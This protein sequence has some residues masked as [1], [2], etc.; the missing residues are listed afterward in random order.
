MKNLIIIVIALRIATATTLAQTGD[1]YVNENH[2][3]KTITNVSHPPVADHD[4]ATKKYVDDAIGGGGGVTSFNSR[5]GVVTS[6]ASDYSS[7]Y[8]PASSVGDDFVTFNSTTGHVLKDSGLFRDT[9]GT[10]TAN[11]DSRIPSQK[12][13]KTY[14]DNS[15]LAGAALTKTDDT[16]ITLTLGGSPTTAL[17]HAASLTLGWNG[18]LA[19]ARG[20]T[21]SGT[22]AGARTNLGA[23]TTGANLFTVSDPSAIRFVKI[24]ADNSVTLDD[25]AS[26]RT[27]IGAGTGGGDFS[28]NTSTSV[29]SEFILFSGTTGKIGKRAT[30]S[31]VALVTSGVFS[32]GSVDLSGSNAS[33]I[34][35]AG[36]F[37]ALTGDVTTSAGSLTTSIASSVNLSG[38]P[39]TTTQATTDNSTRIATTA[40]VTTGIS[41][42]IAGVNPAVAVQAATTAASDTSGFTYS[43]GVGGIGATL[44]GPTNNVAVTFD[45]YTFTA[46]GQRALVKND[47][48]SPSGAFNGVYYV[49]TLQTTGVKPILTRA[50]DFDMP[51][52]INNTGAIPVVNGTANGTTSWVLTSNVTTVGTDPLT[53]T[54]FSLK[55][56]TLVT[57]S[58]T[59]TIGGT[60]QDL[61][62]DRSWLGNVTNDAQIKASDFPS[63]SV[64]SEVVLFSSTTGKVVK[65][66][67]ATGIAKLASG[68]LS[69]V[70][71]PSGAI[72]GDTDTQTLTNKRVNPRTT[73]V[74]S[75]TTSVTIDSDAN[76]MHVTTAQA[77]ALL[78][79]NPSGTPVQ[80]QKLLIRIK[81]N[82]T[83]R[84]LTYGTQFRASSDLALPTTTVVSK[85]LYMG[86]IWNVEDSKWDLL[87]VL[88]NF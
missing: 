28:S 6:Q 19:V 71:A 57:T 16:N 48:Q 11:S 86:F 51:G 44:T 67:S 13:V 49:T 84:A 61:S 27:D 80:G 60:A 81:D 70:T 46:L 9:D 14:V 24:N 55:P 73:T 26:F 74:S 7:I 10:F 76:D 59:L 65:R 85:T 1:I 64:D 88:N 58:R 20:G 87:A 3:N 29:D 34:L 75:T 12:A 56:S 31:G 78:Y 47:T 54:E 63:S 68:V 41:N 52:D 69:S 38:N 39:T 72:V 53:F 35:A 21:G 66:A 43:N 62:A 30:G 8:F 82:G 32:A 5:T 18:T 33:G 77:G 79:N 23:S 42:A 83:A 45:G 15:T 36:R 50:L 17:V 40:Y 25:A 2:H 22:A 4:A 37:P